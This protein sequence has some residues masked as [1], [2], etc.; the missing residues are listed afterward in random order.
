M[1]QLTMTKDRAVEWWDVP[2]PALQDDGQAIVRPLAVALCDMDQPT[3]R[4]ETPVTGPVALGHEFA[5]EVVDV[6]D[7]VTAVSPGDRVV[8]PFQ[9]SCG[10]CDRCR[11]GQTGS[12][13]SVPPLSMYGFGAFGGDWGGAL[14]DLVRVP[15]ADAMLVPLPGN[16]GAAAAASA[17][18][19]GYAVR[20][21][22][23]KS[24][25]SGPVR[26]R[27]AR[28]ACCGSNRTRRR[29]TR[30]RCGPASASAPA[31]PGPS[32]ACGRPS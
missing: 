14:S 11:A 10:T 29:R 30:P 24:A 25:V 12:C 8:V 21:G 16:V 26:R 23:V 32:R 7:A 1:Q 2:A 3:L 17:S 5:A 27:P 18:G 9:I 28:C 13:R 6:G 31:P 20:S 19:G 22:Q 15:Y 4:G